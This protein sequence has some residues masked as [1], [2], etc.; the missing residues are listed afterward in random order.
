MSIFPK[1]LPSQFSSFWTWFHNHLYLLS[2]HLLKKTFPKFPTLC[3]SHRTT[4]L[5][6]LLFSS[7]SFSII[8]WKSQCTV[9]TL[10]T[11]G[12][13]CLQTRHPRMNHR[14]WCKPYRKYSSLWFAQL[15]PLLG[16]LWPAFLLSA[17]F[18]TIPVTRCSFPFWN[19][20]YIYAC[21]YHKM[22][23]HRWWFS[24]IHKNTYFV[25]YF[26]HSSSYKVEYW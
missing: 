2:T 17:V 16:S 14:M 20:A 5:S 3:R 10:I 8:L 22:L 1:A 18:A 21:R 11:P 4:L 26:F 24:S 9:T 12:P 15:L 13:Q 23:I 19:H 25:C 6:P 7:L